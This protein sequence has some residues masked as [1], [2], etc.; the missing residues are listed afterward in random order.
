[1]LYNFYLI[2]IL[3]VSILTYDY[4]IFKTAMKNVN[5]FLGIFLDLTEAFDY[6]T[7]LRVRSSFFVGFQEKHL[8]FFEI[9]LEDHLFVIKKRQNYSIF[10]K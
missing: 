7:G 2:V 5:L 10:N 1:M 8:N 4:F 9:F 3:V 6:V